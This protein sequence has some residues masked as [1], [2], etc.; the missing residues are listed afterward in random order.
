MSHLTKAR[1]EIKDLAALS[2]A[3]ERLGVKVTQGKRTYKEQYTGNVD[4]VMAFEYQGGRAYVTQ[5]Q[6]GEHK[7]T[8]DN[9]GN[10]I[11]QKIGKDC[12]LLGREYAITIVEEQAL[13]MGGVIL[14]QDTQNDGS[15]HIEIS[16]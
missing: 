12:A 10:P 11:T 4:S 5:E 13:A 16:V 7:L 3:A 14:S 15:V 8:I 1:V 9:Y 2:R 6:D